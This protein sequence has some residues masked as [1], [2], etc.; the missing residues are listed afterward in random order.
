MITRSDILEAED[1]LEHFE[2]CLGLVEGDFMSGF[3]DTGEG[4]VTVLAD[5][6]VLG[7]VDF[8]RG[9]AGFGEICGMSVVDRE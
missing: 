7:A 2:R 9:V 8:E 6:T 5:F 4:E 3:V 1:T